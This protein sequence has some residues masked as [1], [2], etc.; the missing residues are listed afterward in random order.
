MNEQDLDKKVKEHYLSQKLSDE[1]VQRILAEGEARKA[2]RSNW[3]RYWMPVA[4][5]A[6][7][8][9][10]IGFQYGRSR[11]QVDMELLSEVAGKIAMKH[12]GRIHR[13]FKVE[14]SD[15][16]GVQA[17]L[18]DLAFSVTPLVKQKLLCAYEV[19]GAK[20]CQLEGQQAAH[21]KV[22]HRVT[23]AI[24]TLYIASLN[25]PLELLKKANN[26]ID[27]EANHVEMWAD[28]GRLFAL[29]D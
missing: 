9:M 13:T 18:E 17:G 29:V 22:R 6:A 26:E 12:N 8:V 28:T 3:W 25:G 23:G 16:E 15:Y 14:A 10:A 7:I 27:L 4:A 11:T 24:C 1:C 21:L 20:Y 2:Q 19:L 5:A